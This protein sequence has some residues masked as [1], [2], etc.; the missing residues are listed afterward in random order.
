MIQVKAPMK[1]ERED[2]MDCEDY[3]VSWVY[4]G[5]LS[6]YAAL[7]SASQSVA[8]ENVLVLASAQVAVL[9]PFTM[10]DQPLIHVPNLQGHSSVLG[11]YLR[12]TPSISATSLPSSFGAWHPSSDS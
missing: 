8:Q 12:R 6:A 5:V 11:A 7:P 10:C 9:L 2:L 4:L 3:V 1:P